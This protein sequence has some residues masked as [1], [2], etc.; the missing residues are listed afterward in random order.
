MHFATLIATLTLRGSNL[1]GKLRA[2]ES[3]NSMAKAPKT[4]S[5]KPKDPD[6]K[7]SAKTDRGCQSASCPD[8]S[9]EVVLNAGP[10]LYLRVRPGG[11]KDWFFWYT[12]PLPPAPGRPKR[13]KL[14]FGSYGTEEDG[15]DGNYTLTAARAK[16]AEY[17]AIVKQGRDP[18]VERDQAKLL[19][20]LVEDTPTTVG[21]LFLRWKEKELAEHSDKGAY[22]AGMLERHAIPHIGNLQLDKLT[23]PIVAAVL[24]KITVGGKLKNTAG[25]VLSYIRQ[26]I[27]FA[28]DR[29]W[30]MGDPTATMR[31]TKWTGK[32]VKRKRVLSRTEI[33]LLA[34]E[35]MPKAELP[36]ELECA[37]WIQL[38]CLTRI[39]ETTRVRRANV[40]FDNCE[41]HIPPEDQKKTHSGPRPHNVD[42]SPFAL[43]WFKRLTELPLE[44]AIRANNNLPKSRRLKEVPP[45]EVN[46]LLPSYRRGDGPINHKTP[47]H[48]IKDRQ[49]PGT[50]PKKGRTPLV[51]VFVL[52]GGGW[53]SHDLRRTGSTMMREL[54][55]PQDV[56]DRCLNHVSGDDMEQTYQHAQLRPEMR[57]AWLKLGEALEQLVTRQPSDVGY[58]NYDTDEDL[59]GMEAEA[60]TEVEIPEEDEDEFACLNEAPAD[61]TAEEDI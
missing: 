13:P 6:D 19:A 58:L 36:P 14:F 48:A 51:D 44:R 23:H 49:K 33:A 11:L 40:D 39:E 20:P 45:P 53:A 3:E 34:S 12:S 29:G 50:I 1:T 30:M 16:A 9:D 52:P 15:K 18:K 57:A 31:K 2:P 32:R 8:G 46:F 22:A 5:K 60:E 17:K 26:M 56:V 37:I 24:D 61:M 35:K 21:Q 54:G 43:K 59:E 4:P 42:L 27:G 47:G 10:G 41:W 28:I 38:A 25:R 55:I 7:Q